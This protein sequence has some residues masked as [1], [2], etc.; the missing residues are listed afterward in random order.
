MSN[1][2]TLLAKMT[3]FLSAALRCLLL[4]ALLTAGAC[5]QDKGNYDYHDVNSITISDINDV[6]ESY[7]VSVGEY[8]KI[9]PTL[10]FS[11]GEERDTYRY[12]WRQMGNIAPYRSVR[13]LSTER[14]LNLKIEGSMSYSQTYYLMYCVTNLTTGVRY[15]HVFK[16]TVQNKISKGY[17]VLHEQAGSDFNI[18]LIAAYGDSLTRYAGVL[19]MFESS[20]PRAG[21]KPLDVLCYYDYTAPT[22]YDPSNHLRYSLWVL[23]D[24]G[25][26]RIKAEDYSYNPDYNISKLSLIPAAVLGGKELV[27]EKMVA[28]MPG[29]VPSNA[30]S[31]MYFN[32]CWFF[33]NLPIMP[34]F[35]N[36]PINVLPGAGATPYTV[37][38]YI[39]PVSYYG[40]IM[41]DEDSRHFML[42][43]TN[44][45]DML[46]SSKIYSSQK[47]TSEKKY[48]AWGDS[49][50]RLVY[51][52]NRT[53]QTGFA[54][55]KKASTDSCALLQMMLEKSGAV[56]LGKSNFQQLPAGLSVE[57][58]KHFA[59][60]PTLPYLYCA[61]EDKVYKILVSTMAIT[62]VTEQ[63]IPAGSKLS[64]LEFLFVRAPRPGLLAVA[65]YDPGGEAGSNGAL[66]FYAAE[67]GTG[68]LTLAPH[69]AQRTDNGYQVEMKWTGFGKI[70]ALDYKEQ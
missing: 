21:R 38:P 57:D 49:T 48:F 20:L 41:F 15:D 8:L 7:L 22:P 69:P 51:M 68:N 18:D 52:G 36:L 23:T 29:E 44:T 65:T 64:V 45:E 6:H 10:K 58:F 39:M 16:V 66:A 53:W 3:G 13:L 4:C 46:N 28:T 42:H 19:D 33:F 62:D 32:G 70:V 40:A 60:H 31:Y 50:Y 55:V 43:Q 35:F 24:K 63:V 25:A 11:L 47:I 5:I 37:A 56:Q 61:T 17:V 54:V 59:Y 26:D 27:A 9:T 67:D 1:A 30:R 14:N 34:Y 2:T 12:E